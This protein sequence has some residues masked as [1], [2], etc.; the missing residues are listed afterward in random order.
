PALLLLGLEGDHSEVWPVLPLLTASCVRS[1]GFPLGS[2]AGESWSQSR[3]S[4]PYLRDTLIDQGIGVETLETAT[5]WSRLLPL[6]EAVK[7][8]LQ[9]AI[10]Q[11]PAAAQRGVVMTHI[12]H[13]Y[14]EGASLYFTFAWP[15]AVTW[16]ERQAQYQAIKNAAC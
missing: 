9:T 6:Y 4:T 12:S 8:A 7:P 11:Q 14:P 2:K 16:A 5:T 13:C 1:G 10:E 3:Y 15:M